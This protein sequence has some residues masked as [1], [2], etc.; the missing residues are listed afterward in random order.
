MNIKKRVALLE[1]LLLQLIENQALPQGC[2]LAGGTAVYF[3][4]RHRFSVDL[5]FFTPKP[6]YGEA[7][8]FRLRE[9]IKDADV[10]LLEKDTLIANLSLEKLKFSLF[11]LPYGLLS[12]L[13]PYELKPGAVCTLA[14]FDDIEAMKAIALVQRGSAKDFI[15]L[16]SLL[17]HTGH[18][19][20][21]LALRVHKKY[22]V[23]EKYDYHLKTAMVYFDDAERE[24]DA[25]WLVGDSGT[26]RS[27]SDKD[28]GNIKDFFVRFCQ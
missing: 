17:R 27:I 15:D 6:F 22:L 16:Y 25:I 3:Y 19:F 28:W 24:L 12:P 4:L 9:L 5:D 26:A 7:L 1:R 20:M 11:Y 2:Y 23:D 13:T 10:E 8:L 21:D 18:S 14:S